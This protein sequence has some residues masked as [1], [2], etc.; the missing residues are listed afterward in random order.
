MEEGTTLDALVLD[1]VLSPS[2]DG[3]ATTAPYTLAF[4]ATLQSLMVTNTSTME[5]FTAQRVSVTGTGTGTGTGTST[6]TDTGTG[7]STGTNTGTSTSTD[8]GTGTTT[9]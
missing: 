1:A 3:L 2:L 5:G 9:Q 6:G 8:T 7:T 4:D